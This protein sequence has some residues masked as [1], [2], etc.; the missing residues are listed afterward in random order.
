MKF[1]ERGSFNAAGFPRWSPRVSVEP[2]YHLGI[3]VTGILRLEG[4]N[5]MLRKANPIVYSSFR[6]KEYL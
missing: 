2:L 5:L 6:R 4:Y 1:L 3:D